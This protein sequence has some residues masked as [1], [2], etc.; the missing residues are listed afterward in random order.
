MK[1]PYRF[2]QYA[3]DQARK[4]DVTLLCLEQG[5]G[6]TMVAM[7]ALD[8]PATIVCP[9]F[10][11]YNWFD[12]AVECGLK[13]VIVKD[14][15]DLFLA[16]DVFIMSYHFLINLDLDVAQAQ[17]FIVDEFH[18]AKNLDAKRT[19]AVIAEIECIQKVMLLS[20]TPIPSRPVEI[21]PILDAIGAYDRGYYSFVHRFCAARKTSYGLDVN[22]ASNLDQLRDIIAPHMIRFTKKNVLKQLPPKHYRVLSLDLEL[23]P[24]EKEYDLEEFKN[25]APD[26]A[27]EALSTVMR[28]HAMVK[29][30]AVCEI[31]DHHFAT[32]D[33][34]LIVF[35]HHRA[36]MLEP[37]LEKYSSLGVVGIMGGVSN[38][39]KKEAERIFQNQD[40]CRLIVIGISAGGVGLTLTAAQRVLLAESSWVPGDIDQATDRA[41]RIGQTGTVEAD[42][43]TIRGSID[44]YQVKRALEKQS[45][46]SQL[47]QESE[48]PTMEINE[49]VTRLSLMLRNAADEIDTL[50]DDAT[51]EAEEKPKPRRSRRAKKEPEVDAEIPFDGEGEEEE[52]ETPKRRTRRSAKKD[53]DEEEEKPKRRTRRSAKKDEEEEDEPKPTRRRR[54]AKKAEDDEEEEE[55]KPTRRTRRKVSAD[56]EEK[57]FDKVRAKASETLKATSREELNEILGEFDVAKVSELE[58]DMYEEFMEMCDEAI[59][60]AA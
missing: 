8:P 44:E 2:Q 57:P 58:E 39:K 49:L 32:R 29:F 34:K 25:V 13:P 52:E 14:Q 19:K 46:T 10:L 45:V 31:I 33:D 26:V 17:T 4:R 9:A 28:L 3:I 21:Y 5:L 11:Q 41:H 30:P 36:E 24:E 38:A 23:P 43:V 37:L 35:G 50:L 7:R 53:E 15:A 40:E 6:K 60:E 55:A 42:I 48:L 1:K 47:L 27:F 59:A 20:G 18:Y 56:D 22:G 12:E 16:A 51:E 54:A